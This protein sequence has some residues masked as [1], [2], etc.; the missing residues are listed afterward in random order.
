L[1]RPPLAQTMRGTARRAVVVVPDGIEAPATL[2]AALPDGTEVAD[3]LREVSSDQHVIV[4]EGKPIDDQ[5]DAVLAT[6]WLNGVDVDW[7]RLAGGRGRRVLLPTYPFSRKRYWAL[8]ELSTSGI[9]A[10]PSAAATVGMNGD[11]AIEQEVLAVWRELFDNTTIGL[12]DE[13]STL[14]GTSL[15]SVQVVLELQERFDVVV[16]VHRAGG[17]KATV[18]S[19]AELVLGLITDPAKESRIDRMDADDNGL[20]DADLTLSLGPVAETQS[21]GR[22][23]LLTG[24][25][26]FLGAFVLPELTR[27]TRGRIYCLVRAANEREAFARLRETAAKFQLP[28]PDPARVFAVPGNLRDI[29]ELSRGYRDGELDERIGHVVHCAARVVFTEPYRIVRE[30]N[31]LPMV[32][33][34]KWMRGCGIGDLS[35]VSTAAATAAVTGSDRILETRN[36]PLDPLLPGYGVSKWVGERL[37]DRADE[38]GMRVRVFRPGLIMSSSKTGAGNAKDLIY[39]VLAA[40]VAV[41]AHPIDD[42]SHTLAPVDVVARGIAELAMSRGSVGRAYHL[43]SEKLVG[44]RHLFELLGEAGL[45]TKPVE[46]KQWQELVRERALVT[47]N[48]ILSTAA[49]LEIEGNEA[50]DP[51]IQATG[52]Q[53]WLRK[54]KLEPEITGEMVRKGLSYLANNDEQFRALLPGLVAVGVGAAR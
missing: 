11:G 31:V 40:G 17:A 54:A 45:P 48:P 14:G 33:L 25:T 4:L 15:L 1:P 37:L 35:F 21:R 16:N 51:P 52:W 27:V 13:F 8:D 42:R 9:S 49:L 22:D 3:R 41:G 34:L 12:D 29:A 32:A 38:D 7:E 36:Q 5:V 50:A 43:V 44:L 28:E 30:D 53:P 19:M 39:F 24:A 2:L 20:V 10:A 23:I 26:G 47:G 18:R 6:A 46:L